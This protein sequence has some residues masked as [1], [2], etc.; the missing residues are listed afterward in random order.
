[1]FTSMAEDAIRMLAE[2]GRLNQAARLRKEVA[3]AYEAEYDFEESAKHYMKAAELYM[4][5]DGVSFANQCY[6]KAADIMIMLKDVN[7]EEVISIFEKVIDE[8]LK[9]D[10]LKASAKSLVVKV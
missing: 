5:E 6:V 2:D 3:E 4:M 8:Y 1:M 10:L 7:Y 9:K